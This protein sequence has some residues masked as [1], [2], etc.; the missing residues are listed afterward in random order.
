MRAADQ[1]PT[2]APR[3][4]LTLGVMRLLAPQLSRSCCTTS[5]RWIA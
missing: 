2:R 3:R 5:H 4:E 1:S